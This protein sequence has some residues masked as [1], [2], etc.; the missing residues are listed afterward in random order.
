[1]EIYLLK[2]SM[3]FSSIG[4]NL[5]SDFGEGS[6]P[7]ADIPTPTAPF[8]FT[9]INENFVLH[10]LL[11][12]PCV[13]KLDIFDFDTELLRLAAPLISPLLTHVY[14]LS[15]YFETNI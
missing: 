13:S 6:L 1:M 2:L 12:L 4:T 7:E 5:T 8:S 11:C 10:Q 9:P 15:L 14:N 3:F